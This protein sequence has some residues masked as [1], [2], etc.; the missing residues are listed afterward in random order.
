MDSAK[1]AGILSYDECIARRTGPNPDSPLAEAHRPAWTHL[2]LAVTSRLEFESVFARGHKNA[3][4]SY[5][6]LRSMLKK[7]K[8]LGEFFKAYG[9]PMEGCRI[10]VDSGAYSAKTLGVNLPIEEYID[11][12]KA[13]IEYISVPIMM[14]A[15]LD[16]VS[17]RYN[18]ELHKKSGIRFMSAFHRPEP[19][20]FF[21]A[22]TE[23]SDYI[24]LAPM[25][26]STSNV[27][28]EWFQKAQ[29]RAAERHKFSGRAPQYHLLGSTSEKVM[30]EMDAVS[31]DSS[32]WAIGA[33]S[34]VTTKSPFGATCWSV[35]TD[36]P[37]HWTKHSADKKQ[38]VRDWLLAVCEL[39]PEILLDCQAKWS[40]HKR[41][42]VNV[43][44][45]KWLEDRSNVHKQ[46]HGVHKPRFQDLDYLVVDNKQMKDTPWS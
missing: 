29:A 3:L 46:L 23:D 6:Y 22:F 32:S 10:M 42:R 31:T 38:L 45:M 5:Y 27:K 17:T 44:Y 13:N 37:N 39:T 24:G 28:I 21:D 15:V 34:F 9:W 16:P 30:M 35:K 19:W 18:Y 8:T 43:E 12:V 11:F 7:Y 2:Y 40:N 25:P 14:D 1:K 33:K 41:A 26:K 20:N 36:N 4:V